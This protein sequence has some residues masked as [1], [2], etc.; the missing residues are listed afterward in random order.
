MLG[1]FAKV[2]VA[3]AN[4]NPGIRDA[5]EWFFEV[6]IAKADPLWLA[7]EV[8]AAAAYQGVAQAQ[9]NQAQAQ[10]SVAQQRVVVAQLQQRQAEESRDFL[11]MKEF[12][13]RPEILSFLR[14]G[15]WSG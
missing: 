6:L 15:S 3:G 2:I 14:G 1:K 13:A 4:L 5:H 9:L 12:S 11:D 8:Q 7:G 10:V